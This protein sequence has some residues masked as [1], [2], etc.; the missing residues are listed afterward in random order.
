MSEPGGEGS[1]TPSTDDMGGGGAL[2]AEQE[3]A[4]RDLLSAA[5]DAFDAEEYE[6]ALD[7]YH[8][9]SLLDGRD[10]GVWRNLGLTYYNLEFPREAWRSYK[11]A[12][13]AD[14]EDVDTLWYAGE[15]LA[16]VEDYAMA[17]FILQRYLE[18]EEEEERC[19]DARRLLAEAKLK[20]DSEDSPKRKSDL[21]VYGDA[22]EAAEDDEEDE[23][24]G[25][26]IEGDEPEDPLDEDDFADIEDDSGGQEDVEGFVAS[27]QLQMG[28]MEAACSNCA[29]AIPRDAPYCYSCNAPYFYP[30]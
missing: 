6:R 14:P 30:D 25:F 21:I 26:E 10:P 15:F 29:T 24:A 22:E 2:S 17:R 9:A 13:Q 5:D 4:K 20:L 12:L 28:G 3:Q 23:L 18:L 19:E 8:R 27:L 7:C 1:Q 11:L 16:A